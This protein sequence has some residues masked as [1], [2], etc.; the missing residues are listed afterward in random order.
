M[1][2]RGMPPVRV[3]KAKKAT[4]VKQQQQQ[5]E[6]EPLL[7]SPDEKPQQ[8]FPR[9]SV[10]TAQIYTLLWINFGLFVLLTIFVAAHVML[11]SSTTGVATVIT[12]KEQQVKTKQLPFNIVS[13]AWFNLSLKLE[14]NVAHYDVCC[15][16]MTRLYQ[17]NNGKVLEVSITINDDVRLH[18]LRQD[19][20]GATCVFSYTTD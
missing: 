8:Q 1:R 5:M 15:R 6:D 16:T 11:A 9:K 7:E 17:C 14:S 4:H 2:G 10:Q 3:L 20:I 19:M 13:D 18:A 12:T